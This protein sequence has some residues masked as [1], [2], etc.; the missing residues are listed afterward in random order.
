MN[1][2]QI[3]LKLTDNHI[4]IFLLKNLTTIAKNLKSKLRYDVMARYEYL[5]ITLK[6]T[7]QFL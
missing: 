5:R 1:R 4:I 2:D 7:T 3:P 6:Q